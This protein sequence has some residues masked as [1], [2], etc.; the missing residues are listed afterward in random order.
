MD[1]PVIPATGGKFVLPWSRHPRPLP[2]A[3]PAATVH[4]AALRG[5]D[6]TVLRPEGFELLGTV[7]GKARQA[8]V[9]SGGSVTE[10]D[11]RSSAMQGSLVIYVN[12]WASAH[13]YVNKSA[14]DEIKP[15]LRDW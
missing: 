14:E 7:M 12:S 8:A 9:I 2:F 13:H 11:D 3:V 10:T 5:M 1:D 6:V 4:I 15:E